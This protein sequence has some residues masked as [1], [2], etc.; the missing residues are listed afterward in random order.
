ME[1][2]LYCRPSGPTLQTFFFG[3]SRIGFPLSPVPGPA[4]PL[5]FS[6]FM[7]LTTPTC[8]DVPRRTQA[9][10]RSGGAR[11][12]STGRTEVSANGGA[13]GGGPGHGKE[14]SHISL[15]PFLL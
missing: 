1:A 14:L 8:F 10:G 15:I 6:C 13:G 4:S 5:A 3:F 7:E 2:S 11:G 12:V 9:E